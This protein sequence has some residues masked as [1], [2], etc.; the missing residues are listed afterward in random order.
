MAGRLRPR[1]TARFFEPPQ[2]G[3]RRPHPFLKASRRT[4]IRGDRIT[5]SEDGGSDAF[6]F[7][8]P[9]IPQDFVMTERRRGVSE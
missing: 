3:S 6:K 1:T 9:P 8:S 2:A 7:L 4:I 5:N